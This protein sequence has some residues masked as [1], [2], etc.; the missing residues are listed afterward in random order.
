MLRPLPLL[1]AALL[2]AASA[3]SVQLNLP[4]RQDRAWLLCDSL[5]TPEV[6]VVGQPDAGGRAEITTLSKAQPGRYS[7]AAWRVGRP[8]PGAGNV[9]YSLTPRDGS[10]ASST[11]PDNIR[12]INPG[13]AA[14]PQL[15]SASGVP[16]LSSITL[17]G[18]TRRCRLA[19]GLRVLAVTERR[20]VMITQ[21]AQG[22]FRYQSFD[23]AAFRPGDV[24]TTLGDSLAQ[25]STPSLSIVGG[26]RLISPA[27]ERYTFTHQGYTYTLSLQSSGGSLSVQRGS[28]PL[29]SEPLRAVLTGDRPG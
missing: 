10:A 14:N 19:P 24:Q 20:S 2:G 25:S 12:L 11:S 4:G 7:Y 13:V 23:N 3:A 29:Q 27:G 9:Y 8:D 1:M 16:V 21:D 28:T 15:Y 6:L 26:T 5:S 18:Q 22:R 17:Q